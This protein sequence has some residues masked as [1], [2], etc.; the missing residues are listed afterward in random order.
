MA[1]LLNL[2]PRYLPRYGMAPD[3]ARAVRPLVLVFTAV[4]FLITWIFDA[5]VDAQ[6]GA[7]A[8][9]VLVLITSAAI[10]VTLAA[11]R[12]RQRGWTH[13]LRG[14]SRWSSLYTT[15]AN[16]V[17]RPDGVKIGACFIAGDHRASR[18]SPGCA[19]AFELRVTSVALDAHQPSVFVR[20]CARRK[21]R[22]IA[23]EP[24]ERD[25][26]STATRSGRSARDHD[27]PGRTRTSSSSRS[28]SPTPPS[29]RASSTVRGEV[30]HGRYRVLTLE[31]SVG[32][33]R[34]R[35]AAAAR[36]RRDRACIPHIYFEWT[37]GNPVVAAP[38]LPPLRAG[39][40]RAGH[41]RGPA[42]GRARPRPPPARPRRLT[43]GDNGRGEPQEPAVR[44][45]GAGWRPAGCWRS[46]A[47]RC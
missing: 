32:P 38:A 9:G 36:P 28:R 19:R 35:R 39:R 20:D 3:W 5:D 23:N 13:R 24:D 6:G 14:R 44:S 25:R 33:Q 42:R 8:T 47:C 21:I 18:C 29:S 11:R 31:A 34:A 7:Y 1:G 37:E 27:L 12:A 2:I 40:G 17:E 10:A 16:V 4:A 45:A 22:F 26:R 41:P 46:S 43:D 30:L 15:V